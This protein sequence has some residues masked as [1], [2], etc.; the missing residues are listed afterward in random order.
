MHWASGGRQPER[1][2]PVAGQARSRPPRG[3][4]TDGS[5]AEDIGAHRLDGERRE[6]DPLA[7]TQS[8]RWMRRRYSSIRPVATSDRANRAPP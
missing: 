7:R 1:R 2:S 3:D 4:V 6:E 8:G 5:A